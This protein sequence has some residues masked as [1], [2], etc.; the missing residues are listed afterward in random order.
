M[1]CA[2]QCAQWNL[3]NPIQSPWFPVNNFGL[4]NFQM[5]HDLFCY[6]D[7]DCLLMDEVIR[8]VHHHH[9]HYLSLDHEGR[10][11]TTDDSQPIST[12][13][14]C[15]PLPS[16]TWRTPGL[17]IPWCFLPTS[18]SVCLVFFPLS[19]CLARC[20]WPDLINGRHDHTTEVCVSLWWSGHLCVV[21][22]QVSHNSLWKKWGSDL[23]LGKS[24]SLDLLAVAVC[25]N[26]ACQGEFVNMCKTWWLV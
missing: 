8:P 9:H 19:L 20:F 3:T 13:F 4:M 26:L 15:S 18:S 10:W 16:G 5:S 23:Q 24:L 12:I 21:Q 17:S 22:V 7:L 6:L 25:H 2:F 1:W 11:G 14:P